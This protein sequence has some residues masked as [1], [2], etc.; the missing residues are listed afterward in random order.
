MTEVRDKYLAEADVVQM[1]NSAV[2]RDFY[3]NQMMTKDGDQV[4]PYGKVTGESH[5]MLEKLKRKQPYYKRNAP[6]ICSFF[7]KGECNR[8]NE[9]P[10]RHEMPEGGELADQNIKD[11]FNGENDPVPRA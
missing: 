1:P 7:V 10:F 3:M 2:N 9:C 11:R 8:G 5:S 6:H 4:L